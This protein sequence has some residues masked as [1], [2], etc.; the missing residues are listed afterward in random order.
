MMYKLFE[1]NSLSPTYLLHHIW[2][3]QFDNNVLTRQT[4]QLPE[5]LQGHGN[6]Y[7]LKRLLEGPAV[8]LHSIRQGAIQVENHSAFHQGTSF[9]PSWCPSQ[10]QAA[11]KGV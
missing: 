9:I 3:C 8:Y 5:F 10:C 11:A 6:P 7:L 2:A 1:V 4:G